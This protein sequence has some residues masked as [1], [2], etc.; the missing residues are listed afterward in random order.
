MATRPKPRTERRADLGGVT[1]SPSP[2]PTAST[3]PEI[4][5][6]GW[7][8]LEDDKGT[9]PAENVAPIVRNDFL[10]KTDKAADA[11]ARYFAEL[12]ASSATLV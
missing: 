3:G 6:N 7:V 9:Q 4:I 10:A 12:G 11:M 8:R 1:A 5:V 2:T